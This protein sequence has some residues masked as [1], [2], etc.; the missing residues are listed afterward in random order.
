MVEIAYAGYDN[1]GRIF[2]FM[3]FVTTHKIA[4][5]YCESTSIKNEQA[6]QVFDECFRGFQFYVP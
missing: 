2:R 4:S 6:K 5:F 1:Q 3:G